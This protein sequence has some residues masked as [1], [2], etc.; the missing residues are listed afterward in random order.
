MI[1]TVKREIHNIKNVL[2]KPEK[3]KNMDLRVSMLIP[4]KQ[5][6]RQTHLLVQSIN[7]THHCEVL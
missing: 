7:D 4:I 3:C 5:P 6:D 1:T 2:S